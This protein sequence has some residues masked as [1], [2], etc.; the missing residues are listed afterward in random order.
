MLDRL[1][2]P[3]SKSRGT[4]WKGEGRSQNTDRRSIGGRRWLHT[5]RCS[6]CCTG[7]RRAYHCIV[8][9]RGSLQ[10]DLFGVGEV[11]GTHPLSRRVAHHRVRNLDR[12]RQRARCRCREARHRRGTSRGLLGAA[13]GLKQT[14]VDDDN[15]LFLTH[16]PS[17]KFHVS[18]GE[19]SGEES[20]ARAVRCRQVHNHS[21][22]LAVWGSRR[23]PRTTLLP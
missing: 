5:G 20:Y 9:C 14:S 16:H 1:C 12:G 11:G 17:I 13:R 22:K 18:R 10:G 6:R 23:D 2:F 7:R 15:C 19:R 8:R 4:L 21:N 3:G